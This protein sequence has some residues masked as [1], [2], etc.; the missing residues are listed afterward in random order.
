ML[1][2][3][4]LM[5]QVLRPLVPLD[6]EFEK[7]LSNLPASVQHFMLEP[8]ENDPPLT[9][10]Y[11]TYRD[12]VGTELVDLVWAWI[13]GG[14]RLT[15]VHGRRAI[16]VRGMVSLYRPEEDPT[17]ARLDRR[18]WK[19]EGMVATLRRDRCQEVTYSIPESPVHSGLP[20]GF[21]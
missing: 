6:P 9:W 2:R 4:R 14:Q 18:R 12:Q 17:S 21:A 7:R 5:P 1:P 10:W 11:L 8:F 20:G 15:F 19:L 3:F 16:R 13:E